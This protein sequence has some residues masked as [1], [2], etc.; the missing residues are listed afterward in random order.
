[1]ETIASLLYCSREDFYAAPV[2]RNCYDGLAGTVLHNAGYNQHDSRATSFAIRIPVLAIVHLA[3][4]FRS[5]IHGLLRTIS[6]KFKKII[7]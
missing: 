5:C 2:P 3:R 4:A 7:I 1:M 6:N